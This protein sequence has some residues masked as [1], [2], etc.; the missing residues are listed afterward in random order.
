MGLCHEANNGA[1][2]VLGIFR[3]GGQGQ[4]GCQEYR[5]EFKYKFHCY[6]CI[7]WLKV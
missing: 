5:Q 7:D 4:N 2:S 1:H 6:I 3:T